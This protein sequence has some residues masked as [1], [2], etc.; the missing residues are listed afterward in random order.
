L[1]LLEC[2]HTN[3]GK[4]RRAQNDVLRVS[5][6]VFTNLAGILEDDIQ[7]F[8]PVEDLHT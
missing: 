1:K 5:P 8:T 3:P 7:G 2:K 4:K 6:S